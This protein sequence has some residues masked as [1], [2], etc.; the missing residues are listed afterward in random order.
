M[1]LF[2]EYPSVGRVL[3]P[4]T[5]VVA[6]CVLPFSLVPLL[7]ESFCR[8]DYNHGW[9]FFDLHQ[10]VPEFFPLSPVHSRCHVQICCR[11]VFLGDTA[12]AWGLYCILKIL[13]VK[14]LY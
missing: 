1:A 14:I 9:G 11:I 5:D 2:S 13:D 8:L 10:E 6:P 7:S 3:L 4:Q 12:V